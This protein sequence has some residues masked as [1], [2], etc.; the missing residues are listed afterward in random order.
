MVMLYSLYVNGEQSLFFEA[1]SKWELRPEKH[2]R[3]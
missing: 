3:N 2:V 1:L